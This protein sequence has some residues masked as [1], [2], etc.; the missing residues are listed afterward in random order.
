MLAEDAPAKSDRNNSK[1]G[2]DAM[3]LHPNFAE[4]TCSCAELKLAGRAWRIA[5]RAK[6]LLQLERQ[7]SPRNG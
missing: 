2:A 1:T 4:L 6:L 7:L 5:Q 3:R